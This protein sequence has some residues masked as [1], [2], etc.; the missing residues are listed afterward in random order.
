MNVVPIFW[1]IAIAL[2]AITVA[3]IVWPLLRRTNASGPSEDAARTA[4]Y[5][6]AKRQLDDDRAAGVLDEASHAAG[7][8][9]LAQRLG[10][11]LDAPQPSAP[12]TADVARPSRRRDGGDRRHS[13]RR[14]RPLRRVGAPEALRPVAATR[15]APNDQQ[16]VA[17]VESLAEKMKA[18]PGD[19]K[20]WRLLARSYAAL[21]RYD[22]LG[23]GV[24][25]GRA[26]RRRGC[27]RARRLG[28]VAR[29]RAEPGDR[30][31]ARGA[32]AP[33]ARARRPPSE[34]A[35][36]GRD[37]RGRAAATS[38]DRSRC[39]VGCTRS[40]RPRARTP[41][42]RSP[43]SA[44]S[45]ACATRRLR[46]A[47]PPAPRDA[48]AR[49]RQRPRL[50]R[51][52]PRPARAPHRRRRPMPTPARAAITGSVDDRARAGRPRRRR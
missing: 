22:G 19:P 29:A 40:S 36:A 10:I 13:A 51:R 20:G 46:K 26:P 25:R 24:R 34:G 48:R 5:R 15:A 49:G 38:T 23:E 33:R 2:L 47:A 17:M 41:R 32:R 16:I 27:R 3:V 6:D 28:R 43:R 30:R 45:S 21:G 12:P 9:E 42:A 18:N 37:R 14:D 1:A 4:V 44:R 31:R 8:A 11:E 50:R 39:G 35:G 52:R 7:V